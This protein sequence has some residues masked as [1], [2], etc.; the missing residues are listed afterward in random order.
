MELQVISSLPENYQIMLANISNDYPMIKTATDNF[1]KTQSQFMDNMLTL[2]QLTEI[3]SARQCLA[4]I[5]KSKLAL[6]EAYF[7]VEKKKIEI[8][9]KRNLLKTTQDEF[10]KRLIEVEIAESENQI[11]NINDNAQGAIRRI[12][13]FMA[14]YKNI[15]NKLGKTELTEEDFEKD[16]E[17]YHIMKSFEQA[18]SAARSRGG[19]IDEGNLIYLFQ[20][21][22]S[23]VAAQIEVRELLTQEGQILS[24]GKIP[25]HAHTLKW[26]YML[27]DKYSGSAERFAKF[28]GLSLIDKQSLITKSETI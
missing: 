3:R 18:L 24:E 22:I 17:R 28:K 14:Q 10:D 9:R 6:E 7:G 19:I 13:G 11:N 27:A 8:D 15:L 16:E 21:G 1:N 5:K 26:L 25:T 2:S 12:S 20:I 23:G 4:E